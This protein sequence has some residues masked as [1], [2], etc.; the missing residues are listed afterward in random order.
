MTPLDQHQIEL[1]KNLLGWQNKPLLQQIYRGF[2]KKIIDLIDPTAIGPTV[3]LGSGI[4]NLKIHLPNAIGTDLFP[5]PWLDLS[6]D[7]YELPFAS[8]SVSHLVLFDVFH[9]LRA[10]KAFLNEARR[11]LTA[12]GRVILFEPFV[13][14]S[15]RPV[16]SVFHHE[17]IGWRDKIDF[18]DR[19]ERP[20]DYYAAQGNATRLFFRRSKKMRDKLGD[21][22]IFHAEAF[23]SFAYLLSGGYSRP[24]FYPARLLPTLQGFDEK[25][26]RWPKLFGAR[27][28]VGL[29]PPA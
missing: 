23:A 7:A 26:S 13:S 19:L 15:S 8:G 6:C 17:P 1:R 12:N 21:W 4:G 18:S 10:P 20:R 22:K 11:V 25:L 2:Y 5:N 14:W 9:H 29:Q 28:L 24:A 27:C 3:E 16:Y